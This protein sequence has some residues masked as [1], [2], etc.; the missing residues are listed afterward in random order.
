[1]LWREVMLNQCSCCRRTTPTSSSAAFLT[2]TGLSL[3]PPT[4][5]PTQIPPGETS[6][7]ITKSHY[8]QEGKING[9]EEKVI[10][11]IANLPSI[12]FWTRNPERGKGFRIN[13]F[14]NHYPDFII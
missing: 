12:A 2:R 6:K 1:M 14:L 5:F 11:E 7:Y 8:E 9:F 10:N 3:S 13:G 4:S